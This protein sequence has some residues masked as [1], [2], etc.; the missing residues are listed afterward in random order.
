MQTNEAIIKLIHEKLNS[1][2]KAQIAKIAALA[3]SVKAKKKKKAPAK[4]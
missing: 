4:K 1:L 2:T 3:K